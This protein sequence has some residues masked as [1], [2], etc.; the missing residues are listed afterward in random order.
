M[1]Q[2]ESIRQLA[3]RKRAELDAISKS[4]TANELLA[5]AEKVTQIKCQVLPADDS[6]LNGAEAV[7]DPEV[8]WIWCNAATD[9]T[10]LSYYKA[11]E[12]AHFWLEGN[13]CA[14]IAT[15]L[16]ARLEEE[17]S[18]LGV[19]RVD[20]YNPKE[21]REAQANVFAREFLL[22]SDL[23]R[24]WFINEQWSATKIALFTELPESVVFH[25][26]TDSLLLPTTVDTTITKPKKSDLHA[27]KLDPSQEAAAHVPNGPLLVEAGPGTGKTRTLVERVAHLIT[28]CYINPDEILVLTF[29]NKAAEEMRERIADILPDQA[30]QIWMGTFHA[31]GLELLR[32]YGHAVGL[33]SNPR[34]LDPVGALFLLEQLLP[35][36]DLKHYLNLYEP[37]LPLRDLLNA[38]SRAKD[39]LIDPTEY[40]NLAEQM[41]EKAKT[42]EDT[43]KAEKAAEVGRVYAIYQTRLDQEHFLDFGD[44]IY[45]SV[46]LFNQ[47][48]D[49]TRDV[50]SKYRHILVDEY[51]DVNRACALLLKGISGNGAGLW[52]VGDARQSI[53]RFRGAAPRN[54]QIFG[55]DFPGAVT[56]SLKRN[57]RTQPV[58]LET[59]ATLAKQMPPTSNLS[60]SDWDPDREQNGGA[61]L[62]GVA[63]D[64]AAEGYGIAKEIEH[65]H[66]RGLAYKEQVILCRSH[67]NLARIA[68][69]LEQHGIPT[70]YMGDLFEREEIR[71]LLS[72]IALAAGDQRS[73][74]RVSTFPQYHIPDKD[75]QLVFSIAG[76][77]DVLFPQAISQFRDNPE[78]S[79]G[80][81]K[82]LLLLDQHLQ[83]LCFGRGVWSLLAHYL[84]NRSQYLQPILNEGNL[85]SQ[86]KRLAIYQFLRFVYEQ[87]HI[88]GSSNDGKRRLLDYIRR[89]EIFGEEKQLRQVPEA[90][91]AIDAVRVMTIHASKGLEFR[92]VYLPMLGAQYFPSKRQPN[93]CPPPDGMLSQN[94]E[95]AHIQEETCLFFVA[96]S[97]AKD[98]LC[99]SRSEHYTNRGTS[100]PSSLLNLIASAIPTSIN[101]PVTWHGGEEQNVERAVSAIPVQQSSDQTFD[102]EDLDL[103]IRCPLRYY[104]ESALG[105]SGKSEETTFLRF[106][107]VLYQILDWIQ[108]QH[109]QTGHVDETT[110]R[111][112]IDKVWMTMN[113]SNHPF[114]PLY[115]KNAEEMLARA[116]KIHNQAIQVIKSEPITISLQAGQVTFLPDHIEVL[117]DNTRIIR[118]IRTGRVSS[119]E[120]DKDIYGLYQAAVYQ[121]VPNK[122]RTDVFS[123][124][125]GQSQ[126]LNLS[127]KKM[128]TR[129]ER[130]NQAIM[131]ILNKD[132]HS[133]P[134]D[135]ECPRCPDYFI[136]PVTTEK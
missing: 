86:Q 41:L 67:T 12:F 65:Q 17:K 19:D 45:K 121:S 1:N 85:A 124:T 91:Q 57:Y 31:Y 16:E 88:Q 118:R 79:E 20:N 25:Q 14:C 26:L 94:P 116:L 38:I 56:V 135:R 131:G 40:I 68:T 98:I 7:L 129:L 136:C 55:H 93:P 13:Q 47:H 72:L 102:V 104:Y 103:Y 106:H 60:F 112:Q 87:E 80:A 28:D 76:Q 113:F 92:A 123:L 130:Y 78:L 52:V 8:G 90:G 133:N 29:S 110:L 48:L 5:V 15:D 53:Y 111:T 66:D 127:T 132:F 54:M 75:V 11:H 84:Y 9:S 73:L 46:Q 70:L 10:L 18:P 117:A 77:K 35:D 37:V 42:E 81:Q 2:W 96:L 119:S 43:E 99:L 82:S 134:S 21:R 30:S 63:D 114:E 107:R 126:P 3:R 109:Q 24:N 44:L 97:R 108:E 101:G 51:Q 100:N 125:S 27:I 61:V 33:S 71:D 120:L 89:L 62:I 23:L 69:V 22:P 83:D 39:E 49:I 50:Q 4:N 6:L 58:I 36:L 105:L 128:E 64:L 115:R 122:C 95:E 59:F 32:K 74:L 34:L